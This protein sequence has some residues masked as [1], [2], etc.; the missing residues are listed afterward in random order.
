MEYKKYTTTNYNL[1]VIKID[2]FKRSYIKVVFK[3]P[4]VKEDITKRII[5]ADVLCESNNFYK[6]KREMVMACEELYRLGWSVSSSINGDYATL[7]FDI[8]FLN[9]KYTESGMVAK[10]LEFLNNIMFKPD[11]ENNGFN[12]SSLELVKKAIK[13]QIISVSESPRRYAFYRLLETIDPNSPLSYHDYGYTEELDAITPEN[14]YTYYQDVMA[15]D[16]VSIFVCGN[17]DD[18]AIKTVIE[19]TFTKTVT[20]DIKTNYIEYQ[21]PREELLIASEKKDVNQS[22][23]M[24][25]YKTINLTPFE[26]EYVLPLYS[27]ILGGGGDSKLF[28]IVRE[29]NSLCYGIRT[30]FYSAF[31][32]FVINAGISNE[33]YQ[34]ALDLSIIE[35]NKMN[36][37]GFDD[38]DLQNAKNTF[39]N[40][41]KEQMD[42]P[43]AI[44]NNYLRNQYYNE[45]LI[46]DKIIKIPTVTREMILDVAKKIFIDTVFLLEGEIKNEKT[47]N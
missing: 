38:G 35:A 45:D 24:I 4:L 42:S 47:I 5:L 16:S 44:A 28:K 18:T 32:L 20:S 33:N 14:L 23:L 36:A 8:S 37:G 25:A 3:R 30:L 7:S 40:D 34:K 31:N 15:N 11:I 43:G 46:V 19:E 26:R 21:K 9:E 6:T 1:H 17:I 39:I 27:F 10:S 13:E 41:Y 12:A 29:K 2:K 22:V